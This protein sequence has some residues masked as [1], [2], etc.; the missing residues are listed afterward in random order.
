[1]DFLLSPEVLLSLLTLTALEIVLGIDNIIFISILAGRV[2]PADRDKA[3]KLGL[4]GALVSRLALLSVISFIVKLTTPLFAWGG[5]EITG[6]GLILL[7]GGLFLLYKA[8]VEIHAKIEGV[9]HAGHGT[10]AVATLGAVVMQITI[11]DIVFSIDS[12]IT[13]VGL[14]PYVSIMVVANL[15]ALAIMLVASKPISD[16]VEAHPTVKVLALSFLLMIGLLL[17]A[18]AFGV[19]VPKGYVYF[20]MGFSVFVE[21]VNIRIAKKGKTLALNLTK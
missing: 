21:L 10:K 15:I 6:K 1:M 14:T 7:V 5:I 16:F 11:L 19:H 18:E 17:V 9:D 3:R 4:M 2:Q 8:T 12:V 20:A 13:A